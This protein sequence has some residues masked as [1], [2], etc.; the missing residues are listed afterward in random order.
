MIKVKKLTE[1]ERKEKEKEFVRKGVG[2]CDFSKVLIEMPVGETIFIDE[3]D[4]ERKTVVTRWIHSAIHNPNSAIF[5]LRFSSY[6]TKDGWV[7]TKKGGEKHE[8][9]EKEK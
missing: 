4:W 9:K 7:V 3:K 6:K 1:A 8:Q 2:P 5:G